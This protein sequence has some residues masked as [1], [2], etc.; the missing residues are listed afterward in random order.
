[1]KTT[2]YS[3][4]LIH[5]QLPFGLEMQICEKKDQLVKQSTINIKTKRNLLTKLFEKHI[6][7]K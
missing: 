2:F 1:M 6:L 4:F 7:S 3:N 5:H